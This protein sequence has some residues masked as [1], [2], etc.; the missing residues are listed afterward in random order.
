MLT[1]SIF[2]IASIGLRMIPMVRDL[3]FL[4]EEQKH[5]RLDEPKQKVQDSLHAALIGWAKANGEGSD[6][7]LN[8]P[9]QC[10]CK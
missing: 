1:Y 4:F 10:L 3:T 6:Y 7:T 8:V 2:T 9:P 5:Q